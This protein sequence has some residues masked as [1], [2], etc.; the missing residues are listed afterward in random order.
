MQRINVPKGYD[1]KNW[2]AV[3]ITYPDESKYSS[4]INWCQKYPSHS[5]FYVGVHSTTW[6]FDIIPKVLVR[7]SKWYFELKEDALLFALAKGG[8]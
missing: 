7:T 1:I 8:V 6:R 4:A 5:K 2:H 3:S